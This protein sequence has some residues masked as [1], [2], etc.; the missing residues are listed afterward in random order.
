MSAVLI[1]WKSSFFSFFDYRKKKETENKWRF[2]RKNNKCSI[3]SSLLSCLLLLFSSVLHRASVHISLLVCAGVEVFI[4]SCCL[5]SGIE[6]L[7]LCP[8]SLS[9][10]PL[11]D[12]LYLLNFTS[13][14]L[15]TC[16]TPTYRSPFLFLPFF[17]LFPPSS[18]VNTP[19]VA[20]ELCHR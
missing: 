14:T 13:R 9:L 1:Q 16:N 6:F 7:H 18:Q 20:W 17:H 2:S 11:S 15:S 10:H 19:P 12:T 3:I 8:C 5:G 4:I